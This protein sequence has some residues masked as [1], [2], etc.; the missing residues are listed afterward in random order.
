MSGAHFRYSTTRGEVTHAGEQHSLIMPRVIFLGSDYT[1]SG[2]R[3]LARQIKDAAQVRPWLALTVD[4]DGVYRTWLPSR[5]SALCCAPEVLV[6]P[7]GAPVDRDAYDQSTRRFVTPTDSVAAARSNVA[8]EMFRAITR[9]VLFDQ[10]AA[11]SSMNRVDDTSDA[12]ARSLARAPLTETSISDVARGAKLGRSQDTSAANSR[13]PDC[14]SSGVPFSTAGAKLPR[15]VA[16]P[17]AGQGVGNSVRPGSGKWMNGTLTPILASISVMLLLFVS[18]PVQAGQSFRV[19]DG[20]SLACGSERVRIVGLDAPEIR[21]RCPA[22]YRLAVQARARL[23]V[24][25]A[26]GVTLHPQGRDRYRRT[27]AVVRDRSGP[28]VAEVLIEEGLARE[29]HGRGRRGGWC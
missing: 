18:S 8:P 28:D 27:L 2:L 26:A 16:C 20:D 14:G 12:C 4:Y 29:Y 7:S 9:T 25:I 24:L 23:A 21:A 11:L 13:C 5:T 6:E 17:A 19:I 3:F 15:F 10:T 1:G 22:E